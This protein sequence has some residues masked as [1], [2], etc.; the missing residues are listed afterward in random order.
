LLSSIADASEAFI[1]LDGLHKFSTGDDIAFAS[2]RLDDSEWRLLQVPGSWQSQG[3]DTH[4][5]MGWYRIHFVPDSSLIGEDPA[6]LL[7]RIGDID[8]VYF[9]GTKI[10]GEGLIAQTFVEATKVQRLYRIPHHLLIPDG[11]NLLAIRVMNTYLHGGIFDRNVLVGDHQTLML[12]KLKRDS[13]TVRS[14]FAFFTFFAIF[15]LTCFFFFIKG[16]RDREYIFFWLFVS[17]YGTIFF[18]G[19]LTFYTTGLKSPFV[20]QIMNTISVLLPVILLFLILNVYREKLNVYARSLFFSYV[21]IVLMINLFPFF[22]V[23]YYF[24]SL[25]QIL[26][27]ITA[28]FLLS[29]AVKAYMRKFYEGAPILLGVAGLIG[30]FI[31][32]SVGGLDLLRTSGFFLW[33]YS[34]V[35]FMMCVMY[36]LASRYTRIKEFQSSSVR[37]FEAHEN[38]RKRLARELHDGIGTSLLA[39][40]MKLQMAEARLRSNA[41]DYEESMFR[42]LISDI[43]HII[44]DLRTAATDLRPSF[45]ENTGLVEA[46]KWHA[47]KVMEHSDIDI[48]V[49]AGEIGEISQKTKE[50]LYRIFQEALNNAVKHSGAER[51]KVSLVRDRDSLIFEIKDNGRGFQTSSETVDGGLGLVTIRERAELLGGTLSIRSSEK[52]GTQLFVEV[53]LK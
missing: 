5:G 19:S 6:V 47:G 33:D 28:V 45:L 1:V 39:T 53:P 41:P 35:F 32:E 21:F 4:H 31:I 16:L 15:F 42:E 38:E 29:Y 44:E 40:K 30:G 22:V 13:L 20:Q 8:E 17:L 18:L 51:V 14:E 48:T 52:L 9:N 2:P 34:A 12:E 50:N 11:D 23:K 26:F 27:V 10:G 25:W 3:V 7:G 36:A 49:H 24:Y 37:I 46:V 43:T